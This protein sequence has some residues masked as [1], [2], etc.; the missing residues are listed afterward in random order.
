MLFLVTRGINRSVRTASVVAGA[1]AQGALDNDIEVSSND[2]T[3]QLLTAL[4][5]MQANLREMLEKERLIAGEN[6]RIREALDNVDANVL[7]ADTDYNIIYLNDAMADMLLAAQDDIRK[8]PA[9]FR[10]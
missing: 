2:E 7:I 1:I 10:C 9:G 3:G 8:E 5:T 6:R 4:Q